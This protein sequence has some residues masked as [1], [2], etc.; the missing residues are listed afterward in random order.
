VIPK[1]DEC[2]FCGS[3]SIAAEHIFS[4]RWLA[5]IWEVPKGHQMP[6]RHLRGHSDRGEEFDLRWSKQEAD[7]VVSCVCDRCNSGWMNTLDRRVYPIVNPMTRGEVVR[8]ASLR[9]Q[10]VVIRWAIKVAFMFDYRQD[11]STIP[12]DFA[13]AFRQTGAIPSHTYVWLARNESLHEGQASGMFHTMGRGDDHPEVYLVTF[14]VDQLV[15]Q[16][17]I[18]IAKDIRPHRP[19]HGDA[20][21]QIWPQNAFSTVV[22]PPS[23]TLD[24]LE[25]AAFGHAFIR[26]YFQF[27]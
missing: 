22:W 20:I 21:A 12:V 26:D 16:V 3:G 9:D 13:R 4:R 1:A 15:V 24:E 8:L 10:N 7:L 5:Q 2:I 14:R 6:H 18:G 11:R 23:R 27:G 19:R 25:Y 17:L